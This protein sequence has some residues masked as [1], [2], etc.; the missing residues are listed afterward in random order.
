MT[1]ALYWNDA[2][3]LYEFGFIYTT[4]ACCLNG[5]EA[6]IFSDFFFFLGGL[7]LI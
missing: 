6:T 1:D 7:W 5:M 4:Y 2:L 3:Y